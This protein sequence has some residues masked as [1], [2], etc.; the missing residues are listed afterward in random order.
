MT[1][2]TYHVKEGKRLSGIFSSEAKAKAYRKELKA[3]GRSSNISVVSGGKPHKA[4]AKKSKSR[5]KRPTA[6]RNAKPMKLLDAEGCLDPYMVE[7]MEDLRDYAVYEDPKLKAALYD[8][9]V[10]RWI[11]DYYDFVSWNEHGNQP[12]M[13]EY[14]EDGYLSNDVSDLTVKRDSSITDY[15]WNDGEPGS[16]ASELMARRADIQNRYGA[17]KR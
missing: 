5:T 2:R 12:S 13:A 15:L 6:S 10:W 9:E 3:E 8:P 1:D 16:T 7:T 14:A 17:I 11:C 4:A